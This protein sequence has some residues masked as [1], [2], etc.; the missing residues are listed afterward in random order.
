[1]K[2]KKPQEV[3]AAMGKFGVTELDDRDLSSAMGSVAMPENGNCYGCPGTSGP[4]AT[5][6]NCHGC[7]APPPPP[8]SA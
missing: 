5:N 8:G 3:L 2:K 7:G 1:M 6:G 4:E